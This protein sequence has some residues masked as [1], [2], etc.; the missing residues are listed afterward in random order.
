[1][2]TNIDIAPPNVVLYFLILSLKPSYMQC[3]K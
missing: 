1:M 2:L 3:P